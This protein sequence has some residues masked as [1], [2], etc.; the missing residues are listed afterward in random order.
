M[1]ETIIVQNSSYLFQ[2]T[3]LTLRVAII[4]STP[5][6]HVFQNNC[7][8]RDVFFHVYVRQ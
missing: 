1:G 5:I 6:V 7:K 2:G 4:K 8:T 3:L